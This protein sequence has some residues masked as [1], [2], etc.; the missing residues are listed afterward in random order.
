MAMESILRLRSSNSAMESILRLRSSNSAMESI[1]R[2]RSS[3]SAMESIL[4][5]RV[6]KQC[7]GKHTKTEGHQTVLWKA[8]SE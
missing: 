3:N 2:L 7:Y 8:Y 4:R 6:I 5:L 1:L